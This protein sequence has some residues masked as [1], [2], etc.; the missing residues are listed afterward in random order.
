[1]SDQLDARGA[2]RRLIVSEILVVG[3]L[4]A[5]AAVAGWLFANKPKVEEKLKE[6][7]PLNVDI[8][9]VQH[10]EHRADQT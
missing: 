4:L 3:V 9:R 10:H 5:S 7:R 8:F 6:D 2:V 1:M